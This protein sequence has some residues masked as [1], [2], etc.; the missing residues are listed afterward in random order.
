MKI[1]RVAD[2]SIRHRFANYICLIGY[3]EY[4]EEFKFIS[5]R[6]ADSAKKT[7]P[8]NGSDLYLRIL[9]EPALRAAMLEALTPDLALQ[10][11]ELREKALSERGTNIGFY[12][13]FIAFLLAGYL[14]YELT[15]LLAKHI[16]Y[17]LAEFVIYIPMFFAF[18]V[19]FPV[20]AI[21]ESWYARRYCSQHSHR[22]ENFKSKEGQQ[23]SLCKRCGLH[24]EANEGRR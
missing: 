2:I 13:G 10:I 16:G 4:D 1:D 21:V 24:F 19:I 3:S 6:Y 17:D 12:V 20:Q 14:L 7:A 18:I 5:A 9:K 15:L 22:L 11:S 8:P 23:F